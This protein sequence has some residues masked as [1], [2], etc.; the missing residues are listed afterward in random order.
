MVD[1]FPRDLQVCT[2]ISQHR[3][4]LTGVSFPTG[5]SQPDALLQRRGFHIGDKQPHRHI[6]VAYRRHP[7]HS[8]PR[9]ALELEVSP[10]HLDLVRVIRHQPEPGRAG[11]RST[12]QHPGH[13]NGATENVL[14]F[15]T[16][17]N[18]DVL[19]KVGKNK[20]T[21]QGVVSG[22]FLDVGEYPG[23]RS[24]V[25]ATKVVRFHV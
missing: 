5:H 24:F 4:E 21:P 23:S 2:K 3:V 13:I 18:H 11:P 1:R 14:N 6:G 7:N 25:I 17:T 20:T 16:N 8:R 22:L 9:Q 15:T 19:L 10:G 12:Q